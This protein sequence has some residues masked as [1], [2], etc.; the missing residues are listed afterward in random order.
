MP[1]SRRF[2]SPKRR[3]FSVLSEYR[4]VIFHLP[5]R[6]LSVF[7]VGQAFI[8]CGLFIM[9]SISILYTKYVRTCKHDC[10]DICWFYQKERNYY[11]KRQQNIGTGCNREPGRSSRP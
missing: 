2:S 11:E 9:V 10:V 4:M 3:V 5:S 7:S 6:I 1:C 8:L